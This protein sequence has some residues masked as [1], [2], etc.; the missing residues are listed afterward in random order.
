LE[1]LFPE[2]PDDKED[3]KILSDEPHKTVN[4][5]TSDLFNILWTWLIDVEGNNILINDENEER[6]PDFDLYVHIA[7]SCKNCVP[8]EQIYKKPFSKFMIDTKIPKDVKL[9]PLFV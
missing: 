2:I 5:T 9:Y 4:E 3:G 6:F 7:T 1:G 8:K